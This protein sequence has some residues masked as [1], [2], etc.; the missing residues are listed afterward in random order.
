MIPSYKQ[1]ANNVHLE[2]LGLEEASCM[3]KFIYEF[4]PNEINKTLFRELLSL[5][6]EEETDVIYN[7]LILADS[8]AL[9]AN[10]RADRYRNLLILAIG[11]N[12]SLLL[13]FLILIFSK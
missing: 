3:D 7:E 9:L 4:E 12:I 1:A 5:S 13:G 10:E 8:E 11:V 6:I 2:E